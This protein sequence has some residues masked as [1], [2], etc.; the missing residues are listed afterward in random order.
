M[1][2]QEQ[3]PVTPFKC[4]WI[5]NTDKDKRILVRTYWLVSLHFLM[6]YHIGMT[7]CVWKLLFHLKKERNNVFLSCNYIIHSWEKSN[8]RFFTE[9][10][11]R[12]LCRNH[13]EHVET[14]QNMWNVL[15]W[16]ISSKKDG[17]DRR[18]CTVIGH[19]VPLRN[20]YYMENGH[21][22][23]SMIVNDKA[24]KAFQW[25]MLP[26]E[27]LRYRYGYSDFHRMWKILIC[28]TY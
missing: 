22:L 15:R 9:E 28:K 23:W 18:L 16:I 2:Q 11:C 19:L 7:Q 17:P 10:T 12:N 14:I 25:W 3:G 24:M 13:S 21:I 1:T 8:S 26:G 5:K 4:H 27:G 20:T 6:I